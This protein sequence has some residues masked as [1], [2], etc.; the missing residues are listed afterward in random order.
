MPE[1]QEVKLL[2][3]E[4]LKITWRDGHVGVYPLVPLRQACPCALCRDLRQRQVPI[5]DT[6]VHLVDIHPVGRYALTFQW[7]DGHRT[8]IYTFQQLR[9]LCPCAQCRS[10]QPSA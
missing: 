4:G 7:S 9:N 3:G 8:G 1:P 6:P 5:P 10:S 2:P